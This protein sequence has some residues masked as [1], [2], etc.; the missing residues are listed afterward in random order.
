MTSLWTARFQKSFSPQTCIE[1]DL[2]GETDKFSLTVLFGRSGEG[3]TTILRALAGLETPDTGEIHFGDECWF[4]SEKG[5]G[6]T[7]QQRGIGYL[8]QEKAL[9]PHLTVAENVAFGLRSLSPSARAQRVDELLSRWELL[10]FAN[11]LP[12]HISGGQQQRT[13]LARALAIRPRILL[14]DEPLSALDELAREELQGHLKEQ[15][16]EYRI[17]TIMVTHHRNEARTLGDRIG[18]LHQGKVAQFGEIEQ[19][20]DRPNTAE[21]ARI[22]GWQVFPLTDGSDFLTEVVTPSAQARFWG[23]RSHDLIVDTP[24][25]ATIPNALTLQLVAME[26]AEQGWKLLLQGDIAIHAT[27]S[28]A[29][30]EQKQIR[31]GQSLSV[32]FGPESARIFSE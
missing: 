30:A 16:A 29:V 11:R 25:E 2:Q 12:R 8:F 32:S 20:F 5:I 31:P 19:V 24:G 23:I 15:L 26:P 21:V 13:A 4:S 17:P 3:K 22:L 27:I 7:P 6:K 10:P 14:L 1:A 18:V 28:R 9:F